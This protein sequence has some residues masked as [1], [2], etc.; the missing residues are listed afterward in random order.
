MEQQKHNANYTIQFN[1]RHGKIRLSLSILKGLNN[2]RY[3]QFFVD[4]SE[5]KLMV[6][7][8]DEYSVDC[9]AN[10]LLTNQKRKEFVLN[11]QAFIKTLCDRMGW[12]LINSHRFYG[13]L[14][15]EKRCVVFDLNNEIIGEQE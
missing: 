3:V 8:V 14:D 7:G 2:P 1:Y 9:I 4:G 5:R 12:D 15:E 10:P 6:V 13:E 11:G